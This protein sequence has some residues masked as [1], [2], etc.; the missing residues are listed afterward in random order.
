MPEFPIAF[1]SVLLHWTEALESNFELD[2]IAAGLEIGLAV[3]V[4][5]E[6]LAVAEKAAVEMARFEKKVSG[7]GSDKKK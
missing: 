3:V 1:Q 7:S 4:G 2:Q 6:L 5:I